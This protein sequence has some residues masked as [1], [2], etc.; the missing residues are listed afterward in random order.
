MQ[1]YCYRVT[2]ASCCNFVLSLL[3]LGIYAR[4]CMVL[5]LW[6]ILKHFNR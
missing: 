3:S 5:L 2:N 4:T 1:E 6:F